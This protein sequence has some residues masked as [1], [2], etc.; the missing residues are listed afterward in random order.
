MASSKG[1]DQQERREFDKFLKFLSLKVCFEV[2]LFR[3]ILLS[4]KFRILFTSALYSSLLYK[5][6]YWLVNSDIEMKYTKSNM[7]HVV[8]NQV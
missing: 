4:G 7:H 5:C 3:M 2:K 1:M 6:Y 8:C